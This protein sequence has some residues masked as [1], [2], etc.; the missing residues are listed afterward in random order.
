MHK[1]T[2]LHLDQAFIVQAVK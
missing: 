2:V 1:E